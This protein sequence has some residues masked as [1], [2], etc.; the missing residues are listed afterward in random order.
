MSAACGRQSLET[1]AHS[2][3]WQQYVML[4][5]GRAA[6]KEGMGDVADRVSGL[7]VVEGLAVVCQW[8]CRVLNEVQMLLQVIGKLGLQATKGDISS[9]CHCLMTQMLIVVAQGSL[10]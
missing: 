9:F 8:L 2:R 1:A 4:D 6:A 7:S 3:Q 10:I 5:A